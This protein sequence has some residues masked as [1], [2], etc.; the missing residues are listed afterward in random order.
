MLYRCL[1]IALL[2]FA[3]RLHA[4][5]PPVAQALY[6]SA[7][8]QD[9]AIV[10]YAHNAGAQVIATPDGQSFYVQWFPPGTIPGLS[11]V[12]VSLHGSEGYAFHEFKN[13]HNAA[14]SHNCGIIA[15]Q[16]YRGPAAVTP[17]D[18]FPD[19]TLYSYLDSALTAISYPSGKAFLHGFSRGS[20][21]SYAINF[22][23]L[24]GGKDYFCTTLSNAGTADSL[25][26]LYADIIAGVYGPHVFAGKHWTLFCGGLDPNPR[27]SGCLGMSATEAWLQ[28]QGATVDIFL[29]APTLGH[30]GFQVP[31]AMSN[32]FRDSILDHYLACYNGS[33]AALPEIAT[34][35]TRLYCVPNPAANGTTVRWDALVL[36]GSLHLYTPS[37]QLVRTVRHLVGFDHAL[38]ASGLLPGLYVLEL[39][40]HDNPIARTKFVRTR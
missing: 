20:A 32:Q 10:T 8:A 22:L 26:P 34:A 7:V 31:S 17:Y 5:L 9:P 39:R 16:W 18:Y 28:D 40:E 37:G 27:Q 19:D 35:S 3:L 11:P 14:T 2:L 1:T 33:L 15:L 13:W 36:D 21:R 38:D 4:Q 25:Y 24:Q 30:D 12:I 23:D 29:Q 6:D